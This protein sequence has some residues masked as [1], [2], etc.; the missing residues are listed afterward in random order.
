MRHWSALALILLV[1]A[2]GFQL[3]GAYPL[4]FDK[5]YIALPE[6][7]ELHAQLKRSVAASSNARIVDSQKDAQATLL[8]PSD[9]STKNILSLSATGRA[10]EFQLVRIFSF[11]LVDGKGRDWLPPSQIVVRRD[12]T[13]T[14]DLVL[15]KEA[16]EALLWRDIQNDLVQQILRRLAA[17]K[18]PGKAE[19]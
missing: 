4:P 7:T 19:E 6:T 15:S 14:D 9:S 12:I 11:R 5:L 8:I 2:C 13:F 16:E 3:R 18:P 17:A 10:R 1:S